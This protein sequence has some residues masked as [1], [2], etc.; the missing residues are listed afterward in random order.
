MKKIIIST[1]AALILLVTHP[2]I[3]KEFYIE[4][5]IGHYDVDDAETSVADGTVNG[6]ALSGVSIKN[7]YDQDTSFGIEAGMYVTENIRLAISFANADFD[8]ESTS[9]SGT[10]DDGSESGNFNVTVSRAT[11]DSLGTGL[12]FDNDADLIM[13]KAYYDFNSINGITPYI[14]F[15]L[16]EADIENAVDDE[17][18]VSFSVGANYSFGTNAYFGAKVTFMEIDGPTDELGFNYDDLDLTIFDLVVGTSF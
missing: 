5:S 7:K 10:Y 3:A 12:T 6:V 14:S 1:I 16:G 13:L 2:V 8:F 9:G 17:T 15:G 4:G 18:A 11:L